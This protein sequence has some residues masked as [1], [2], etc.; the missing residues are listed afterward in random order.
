[1]VLENGLG[2][3]SKRLRIFI[4]LYWALEIIVLK[5]LFFSD[6]NV[7]GGMKKTWLI[8]VLRNKPIKP[9]DRIRTKSSETD[10]K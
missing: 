10:C 9:S 1:M 6:S 7:F 5:T 8:F 3:M 4:T 2:K